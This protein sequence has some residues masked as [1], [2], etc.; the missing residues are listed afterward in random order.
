MPSLGEALERL[1]R[2][3]WSR[4][5]VV[6]AV[7]FGSLAAGARGRDVD[8]LAALRRGVDR[9]EA[10]LG[11]A[12]EL[13]EAL[14]WSFDLV[15]LDEAPCPIVMDA[16][17]RGVVVYEERRGLFIDLLLPR[18][19]LCS[20]YRLWAR[21]LDLSRVAARAARRRWAVTAP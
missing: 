18:V 13:A 5:G 16:W 15:L 12:A 7:V 6:L 9:V 11:L 8:V 10:K 2:I 19:A 1:R 20:D 4:H 14:P 3:P 17:R 21:K